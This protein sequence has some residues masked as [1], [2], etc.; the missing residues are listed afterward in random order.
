MKKKARPESTLPTCDVCVG[1]GLPLSG[2]PC[3]FGGSGYSHDEK[4][5]LRRR[6]Y[7][8]ALQNEA[9]R[10][11]LE[12]IAKELNPCW[13]KDLAAS[14]IDKP[15][16]DA[17]PV[18]PNC[19]V[20]SDGR[21]CRCG[22]FVEKRTNESEPVFVQTSIGFGCRVCGRPPGGEGGCLVCQGR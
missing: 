5:G 11:A 16:S 1:S 6:V 9:M 4:A 14:V 19:G 12:K 7:E 18:C 8:L 17:I 15:M 2:K 3:I 20:L 13:A 10:N 21:K 22:L